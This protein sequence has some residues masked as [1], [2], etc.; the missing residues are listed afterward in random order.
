MTGIGC[1]I[2][3]ESHNPF[4]RIALPVVGYFAA[5]FLH[6]LWNGMA[7]FSAPIMYGMGFGSACGG[8]TGLMGLCAFMIGYII[9]EIPLF[10][11]FT[12]W[13]TKRPPKIAGGPSVD[14]GGAH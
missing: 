5:V 6:A 14:A 1:G 2:S 11:I 4:L 13:I 9:L 12:I 3:R 8:P 7:V 10:L